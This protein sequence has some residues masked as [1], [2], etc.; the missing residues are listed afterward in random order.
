MA[1]VLTA[2]GLV[3]Y[4]TDGANTYPFA[5]AKNSTITIE[6]DMIELAP[7]TNGIFRE[8]IKGR[9]TFTMSGTGLIKI[10]QSGM[11]PISFFDDF[12]LGTDTVYAGRFDM[13]DP[14]SNYKKFSFNCYITSLTL[15]STYGQTPSYSYTL[16]GTGE[17]TEVP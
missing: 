10:V 13:I 3:L 15:E 9:Q 6:A 17:F 5:C 12:I 2:S 7:K 4:I 1:D 8:F 11:Q 14:Q 16:Q